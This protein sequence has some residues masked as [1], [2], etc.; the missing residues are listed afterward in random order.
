MNANA[1]HAEPVMGSSLVTDPNENVDPLDE[2]VG[3][4]DAR[5]D[6]EEINRRISM[7]E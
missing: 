2:L 3:L 1:R 4:Q 6:Q 7:M 5:T